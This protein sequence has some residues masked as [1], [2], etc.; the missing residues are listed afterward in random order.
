MAQADRT[1]ILDPLE[2]ILA[3]A[4]AINNVNADSLSFIDSRKDQQVIVDRKYA[5]QTRQLPLEIRQNFSPNKVQKIEHDISCY[6]KP[7]PILTA[8]NVKRD[9]E[10][11]IKSWRYQG[12]PLTK[13][14]IASDRFINTNLKSFEDLCRLQQDYDYLIQN[15]C[16]VL[17][18]TSKAREAATVILRNVE[19]LQVAIGEIH[20]QTIDVKDIMEGSDV[21]GANLKKYFKLQQ[22]SACKVHGCKGNQIRQYCCPNFEDCGKL[23]NSSCIRAHEHTVTCLEVFT[24]DAAQYLVSGSQDNS[25][26]M[27]DLKDNASTCTLRGHVNTV[28]ALVFF[29]ENNTPMLASGSDDNTIKIWDL[30]MK[31]LVKTIEVTSAV[32]TLASF[33]I[34]K[35]VYLASSGFRERSVN[36]WDLSN[37]DPIETIRCKIGFIHKL[38]VFYKKGEPFLVV[39]ADNG[40]SVWCLSNYEEVKKLEKGN[41]RFSCIAVVNDGKLI[42]VA[43]GTLNGYVKLWNLTDDS[44]GLVGSFCLSNQNY[45]VESLEWILCEGKIRVVGCTRDRN[46]RMWDLETKASPRNLEVGPSVQV[47]KV[48]ENNENP[49]F[50]TGHSQGYIRFWDE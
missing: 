36:F 3:K 23:Y 7:K 15:Y 26:R 25:L 11:V 2:L 47:F 48:I 5:F 30:S 34:G 41:S 45:R 37:Y 19:T 12:Y 18:D 43:A 1:K 39:A 17:A 50:V 38:Q 13:E 24:L 9:I 31:S 46:L 29:M 40:I 21:I 16:Q 14:A 10:N 35:K 42:V 22:V 28:H 49:C 44:Y 8:Q 20:E 6:D 33:E 32:T 4:Q 27:W